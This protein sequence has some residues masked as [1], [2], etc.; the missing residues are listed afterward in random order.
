MSSKD[1]DMVKTWKSQ[2]AE[3]GASTLEERVLS[4][5]TCVTSVADPKPQKKTICKK[6]FALH[7]SRYVLRIFI[8]CCAASLWIF[9]GFASPS[10]LYFFQ[11]KQ[12][13]RLT[14]RTG[15]SSWCSVLGIQ[16][17]NP[18]DSSRR[19]RQRRACRNSHNT[20]HLTEPVL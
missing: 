17:G 9:I 4:R 6:G 3:R 18:R 20:H 15:R 14:T 13:D 11:R 16:E 5:V 2:S 1:T 12:Y 8:A 19:L 10:P 7:S